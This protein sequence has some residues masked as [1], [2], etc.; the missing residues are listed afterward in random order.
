MKLRTSFSESQRGAILVEMA[1]VV[2]ILAILLM[3][4]VQFGLVLREHQ[5]VQNA[6]REGARFSSQDRP[7]NSGPQPPT[8]A[9]VRSVVRTYLQLEGV[10]AS[11]ADITVVRNYDLGPTIGQCGSLVRITHTT[12]PVIGSGIWGNFTY[13]AEAVFRNLSATPC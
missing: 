3:G 8:A 6:A 1:F 2:P 4:T 7:T 5:I 13:T 10:A 12:A 11:D 9:D